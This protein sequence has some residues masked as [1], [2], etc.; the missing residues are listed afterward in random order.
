MNEKYAEN[1]STGR[2]RPVGL[3]PRR[4]PA[5]GVG[6]L[7][8]SPLV[9]QATTILE[10]E[11][12]SGFAA[13]PGLLAVGLAFIVC[14]AVGWPALWHA[15]KEI[16]PGRI[17]ALGTAMLIA[18]AGVGLLAFRPAFFWRAM[19]DWGTRDYLVVAMA[20]LMV[21]FAVTAAVLWLLVRNDFRGRSLGLRQ[22]FAVVAILLSNYLVAFV[23][24]ATCQPHIYAD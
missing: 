2:S 1:R 19:L 20:N 3:E 17:A 16:G 5:G 24:Y 4:A 23:V 6:I 15:C 14:T 8:L 21:S 11:F 18:D 9:F 7:V 12:R 10:W 13:W 22:A